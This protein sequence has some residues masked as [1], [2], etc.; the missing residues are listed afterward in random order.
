MLL[1]L[2]LF[3]LLGCIYGSLVRLAIPGRKRPSD[4]A[5]AMVLGVLGAISVQLLGTAVGWYSKGEST[6]LLAPLLASALLVGT[7]EVITRQH[8]SRKS[9]NQ[10]AN[11]AVRAE[12]FEPPMTTQLPR[13]DVVAELEKLAA[14]LASGA[15]DDNEFKLMK[16]RLLAP[17]S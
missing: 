1:R 2:F 7:W 13:G 16:A 14:L 6:G 15:I 3:V 11:G 4:F 17:P 12:R 10:Y 5:I 9:G 8:S